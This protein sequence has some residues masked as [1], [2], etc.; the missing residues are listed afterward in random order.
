[1]TVGGDFIPNDPAYSEPDYPVVFGIRLTPTVSGVLLALL[2]LAGAG[3]IFAY[4]LS[5]EW[6]T[7]QQ[8]KAKVEQTE[9]ELQQKAAIAQ[10]IEAAKRDLENA[11]RQ[12]GEVLTLFATESAMD[13]LPLDLNRQINA[14]NA[15]LAR[16]RE[17]QLANCPAV[18]RQ[19]LREF[20]DRFGEV[21]AKAELKKFERPKS[22][23]TGAP[24][25]G[26]ITDGA[27]GPLVDN[28]LKRQVFTVELAGNY[29]QTAAILENI[30]RLQPMLVLRGFDSGLTD[31][32]KNTVFYSLTGDR[33][34][35]CQIDT[36]INT[37]F[38]LEAL[39]PL[40][41]AESA[42]ASQA[43]QAAASTPK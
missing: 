20:E 32:I 9:A 38:Y 3:A 6:E 4:L 21:A 5:P 37:K 33:L 2:G 27:Y 36:K 42:Q 15:D 29:E 12:R 7:Y 22:G 19:N 18:V 14:R 25:E 1:M 23:A 40:T 8:L 24:T 17:Q 11:R 34:S 10:Q 28:K 35:P 39:L 26:I 30:E 16:R 43:Q 31:K 41:A 13:T